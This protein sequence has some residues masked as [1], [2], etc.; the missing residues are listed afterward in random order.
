MEELQQQLEAHGQ[1]VDGV[2]MVPLSVAI[3]AIELA[4]SSAIVEQLEQAT[5][6]MQELLGDYTLPE[7]GEL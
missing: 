6:H 2:T 1:D 4:R 7:D 5:A 3:Q